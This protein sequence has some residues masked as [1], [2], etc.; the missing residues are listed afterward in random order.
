MK[1]VVLF[2]VCIVLS[3]ASQANVILPAIFGDHMV[4]QQNTEV[5]IWGWAKPN[6]KISIIPGWDTKQEYSLTVN[7]QSA[8]YLKIKTPNA[9]GPYQLTIKG[10]NT[11]VIEDVLIGEVWLGSGQSNMEWSAS[12]GITNAEFE[13]AKAD[14]PKIRF[15]SAGTMAASEPQQLLTGKWEVCT[16]QTMK[17]FSAVLYF[18]G[19]EI[20]EKTKFPLGLINSSW[21]GTPVEIWMS[22]SSIAQDRI[23]KENA[24]L[25]KP[26]PWGPH[27]PGRAY[28]SMIYPLAPYPI[29]GALWYQ[30]EGN[31]VN[32]QHYARA[33]STL[34][35]DWRSL[36]GIDFSFYIAQ[37]AP[38]AGYGTDNVSGA[39]IRDQQRKVLEMIPHTGM[40]VLS[41]IGDL[42]DI[43]PK[44]KVD[45]GKRLALWALNKDYNMKDMVFSGPAYSSFKIEGDKIN[46]LFDYAQGLYAKGGLLNEIEILTR[47]AKWISALAT[48]RDKTVEIDIKGVS[49]VKGFRLGYKNDSNFNLFNSAGLPASCFEVV[50]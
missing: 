8:W 50:F 16:P 7:N 31:T 28:N 18:F 44:N 38:F 12:S 41:D 24:T 1:K 30:G 42:K 40:A 46:I 20:H 43:H 13:T 25:L 17:Y 6:E 10:Y 49:G 29:K 5:T 19:R 14:Y 34:I 45:V 27:E 23:L 22:A 39:V 35:Q 26:A 32:G 15:F 37:I 48:V 3:I 21:G 2:F 33:L 47:D 4:L 9:G 11:I 36:W